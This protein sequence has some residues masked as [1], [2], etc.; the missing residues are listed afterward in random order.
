MK[1][2]FEVKNATKV[3]LTMKLTFGEEWFFYI[4][5]LDHLE[6]SLSIFFPEESGHDYTLVRQVEKQC[7]LAN[8]A[9]FFISSFVRRSV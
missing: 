7:L 2:G 8:L 6:N 5:F 4:L 3:R 1:G 9:P